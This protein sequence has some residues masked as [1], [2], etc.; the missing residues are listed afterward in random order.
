MGVRWLNYLRALGRI[1][2]KMQV[3]RNFL[4]AAD[5]ESSSGKDVSPNLGEGKGIIYHFTTAF[6]SYKCVHLVQNQSGRKTTHSNK[7]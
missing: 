3:E 6:P 1:T 4:T 7:Q 2:K 5:A